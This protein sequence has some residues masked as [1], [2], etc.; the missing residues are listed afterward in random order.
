MFLRRGLMLHSDRGAVG[1]LDSALLPVW[2]AP[3]SLNHFVIARD[4]LVIDG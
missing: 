1:S 3:L 4:L 2:R